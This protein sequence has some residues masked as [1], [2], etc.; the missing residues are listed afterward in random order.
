MTAHEIAT[1]SMQAHS[2]LSLILQSHIVGGK[3]LTESIN[4]S[5]YLEYYFNDGTLV[6]MAVVRDFNDDMNPTHVVLNE[7]VKSQG[8]TPSYNRLYT[9]RFKI[10]QK[11]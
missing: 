2:K 5:H 8:S 6:E 4:R 11:K 3:I 9:E 1:L 7:Y 10:P